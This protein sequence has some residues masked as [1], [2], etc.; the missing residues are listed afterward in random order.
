MTRRRTVWAT[1]RDD[2]QQVGRLLRRAFP[3]GVGS[4][5]GLPDALQEDL[6][7]YVERL[8]LDGGTIERDYSVTEVEL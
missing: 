6:S 4:F 2:R 5:S 3:L 7:E 1:P 8:G